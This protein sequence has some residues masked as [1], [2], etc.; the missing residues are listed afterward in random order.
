M[1]LDK[2]QEIFFDTDIINEVGCR[3]SHELQSFHVRFSDSVIF[4][5]YNMISTKVSPME[6]HAGHQTFFF[7]SCSIAFINNAFWTKPRNVDPTSEHKK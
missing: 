1:H 6:F 7:I 3:D 4:K 5:Y 2:I